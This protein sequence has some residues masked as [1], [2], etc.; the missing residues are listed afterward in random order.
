M[1]TLTL[2]LLWIVLRRRPDR[3]GQGAAGDPPVDGL[4]AFGQAALDAA[5][6]GCGCCVVY[7]IIML[8]MTGVVGTVIVFW[9]W[10][11]GR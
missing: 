8:I 11:T 9:N 7:T 4:S 3:D 1:D 10:I 6:T 5:G 2:Y